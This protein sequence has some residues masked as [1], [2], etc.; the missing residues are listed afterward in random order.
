MKCFVQLTVLREIGTQG[1]SWNQHKHC[2]AFISGPS[3][4]TIRDYEDS[5]K[6]HMLCF[7]L[8]I[9]MY[10]AILDACMYVSLVMKKNCYSFRIHGVADQINM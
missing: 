4:V 7:L 3:Q 5:G 8:D 6:L 2:L 10:A 1:V 9:T